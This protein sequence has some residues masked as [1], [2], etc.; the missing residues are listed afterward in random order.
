LKKKKKEK[1]HSHVEFAIQT[2]R[3]LPNIEHSKNC[4][5]QRFTTNEY[6]I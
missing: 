2:S 3:Q 1:K 4:L 5:F 6:L